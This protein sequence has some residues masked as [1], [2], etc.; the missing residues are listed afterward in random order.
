MIA[1][2]SGSNGRK[3]ELSWAVGSFLVSEAVVLQ[4]CIVLSTP[5]Q[6]ELVLAFIF[7]ASSRLTD[8][9][10]DITISSSDC[11]DSSSWNWLLLIHGFLSFV[12]FECLLHDPKIMS[13]TTADE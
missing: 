9:I 3:S 12:C 7:L 11:E 10:I 1:W 4:A 2:K 13:P 6:S 5:I 8:P